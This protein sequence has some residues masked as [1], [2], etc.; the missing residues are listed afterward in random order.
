MFSRVHSLLCTDMCTPVCTSIC[1]H[2]CVGT[3]VYTYVASHKY[4]T[5]TNTLT[6]SHLVSVVH[7][8]IMRGVVISRD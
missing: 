4:C 6:T 1:V 2:V 5:R 7:V 3:Y 8:H